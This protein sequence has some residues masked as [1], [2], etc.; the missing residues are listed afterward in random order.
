[1]P[2]SVKKLLDSIGPNNARMTT[3]VCQYPRFVHAEMMTHKILNKNSASSRAIPVA[4][5]LEQVKND[6]ALPLWWGKN[7]AGMQA[8]EELTGAALNLAKIHWE[9]ARDEM[10]W[11]VERLMD[12]GLHKQLA[13][14]LLEPWMF[15]T[16]ILTGTEY[17]NFFRL[18]AHPDAQ[19]EIAWVATEMKRQY[20]ETE[21]TRISSASWHLPFITGEDYASELAVEQL[22]LISAARCARVS[23]LTH[24]G[25]K[26]FADDIA[27]AEKLMSSGHWSPFEHI[28]QAQPEGTTNWSGNLKGFTQLRSLLDPRFVKR[29]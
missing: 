12:L 6:P 16:I 29:P 23:Y 18:R 7:Q 3:W 15:I 9:T 27:L 22:Q 8:R 5:L 1:M 10:V 11:A 19:P 4:K 24:D 26:D 21:P 20:E 25:R 28:A 13:N 17:E 2:Y 14:R